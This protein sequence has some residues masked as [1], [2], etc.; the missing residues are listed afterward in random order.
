METTWVALKFEGVVICYIDA[1]DSSHIK[2]QN[3]SYGKKRWVEIRN[4]EI[5]NTGITGN[6]I[7]YNDAL[8]KVAL[9]Q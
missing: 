6:Q 4:G 2:M 9:P 1:S 7:C 5:V 8:A 3:K